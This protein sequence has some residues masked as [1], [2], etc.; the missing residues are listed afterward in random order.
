[1][2]G[3]LWLL[4]LTEAIIL[5]EAAR[6]WVEYTPGT[7]ANLA[8][9]QHLA[10]SIATVS[11]TEPILVTPGRTLVSG[12]RR[13]LAHAYLVAH[14]KERFSV[15]EAIVVE[16]TRPLPVQLAETLVREDLTAVEIGFSVGLLI[17][18]IEEEPVGA[19]PPYFQS[20]GTIAVPRELR[21]LLRKRRGYGTWTQVSVALGK[22]DR[23]WR[24]YV[25]LLSLCDPALTLAHRAGLTEWALRDIVNEDLSCEEQL[26]W[27]RRMMAGELDDEREEEI[28]AQSASPVAVASVRKI[29]SARDH[30]A[31]FN[32]DS[33]RHAVAQAFERLNPQDL[34][35]AYQAFEVIYITLRDIRGW[36]KGRDREI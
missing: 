36:H 3:D 8:D 33:L 7:D 21:D 15:I 28:N 25:N 12:L 19:D 11:L 34:E 30:L 14:G 20:D 2:P 5:V 17:A 9:I 31:D 35:G 29:V 18:Q 10:T 13:L 1:M 16:E 26:A 24:Q 6:R 4:L 32:P 22:S 27:I 23:R